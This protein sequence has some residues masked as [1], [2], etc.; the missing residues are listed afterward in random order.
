MPMHAVKMVTFTFFNVYLPAVFTTIVRCFF[1]V[2]IN[3]VIIHHGLSSGKLPFTFPG[4]VFTKAFY[5]MREHVH[6]KTP[7]SDIFLFQVLSL[8]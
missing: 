6:T 1:F 8:F 2:V 5:V 7:V 3:I 4:D